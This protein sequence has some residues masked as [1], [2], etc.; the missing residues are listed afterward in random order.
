MNSLIK[1]YKEFSSLDDKNEIGF[2]IT[3]KE[4]LKQK[5]IEKSIKNNN[6]NS[7]KY[8]NILIENMK[9][10]TD[11]ENK[12]YFETIKKDL[13]DRIYHETFLKYEEEEKK[14]DKLKR[15]QKQREE[16][17]VECPQCSDRD[18]KC[19]GRI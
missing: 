5:I 7:G 15:L 14:K 13:Y 17:G 16:E 19:Q 11:E 9:N 8:L 6:T 1:L 10:E 12:K 18:C 3:L 4:E 2:Y